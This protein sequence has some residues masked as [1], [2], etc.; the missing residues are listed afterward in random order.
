MK[1][2]VKLNSVWTDTNDNKFTVVKLT[3]D[4]NKTWIHYKNS[5]EQ[6]YSCYAEAFTHR[7]TEVL[8]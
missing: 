1:N 6:Q 4:N 5:Q 2:I 7:F 8:Q 3:T